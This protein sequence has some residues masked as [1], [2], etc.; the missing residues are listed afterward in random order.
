[1]NLCFEIYKESIIMR[2]LTEARKQEIITEVLAAQENQEQFLLDMKQRQQEGL[3]VAKKCADLLKKKYG[4]TKVVLFGSLLNHKKIT[5]HSDIDL[6]VWNL[7]G[8]DYFK[9]SADLDRQHNFEVDLVEIQHAPPY[10][11]DAINQG[12]EL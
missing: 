7:P 3:R 10:I 6:A 11:L 2:I 4:V 9:A 12:I 5:Y 8:K 1:M